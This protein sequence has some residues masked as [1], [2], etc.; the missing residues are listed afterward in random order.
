MDATERK[1]LAALPD[2]AETAG[3]NEMN[4]NDRKALAALRKEA[5]RV[6][7]IV[8]IDRSCGCNELRVTAPDGQIFAAESLHEFV[9]CVYQPWQPD[10]ADALNR[11]KA[12]PPEPC[13]DLECEWCNDI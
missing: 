8:S 2:L 10:Y 9:D 4:T 11:L 1:A 6:G 13:T 3:G 12:S 7:A 5:T